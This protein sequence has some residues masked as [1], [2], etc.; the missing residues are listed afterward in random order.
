M[1][2]SSMM[3]ARVAAADLFDSRQFYFNPI[4]KK[5]KVYVKQIK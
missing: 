3:L 2:E 4:K 1:R 5:E